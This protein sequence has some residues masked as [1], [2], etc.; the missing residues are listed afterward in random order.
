M[1]CQ[2]PLQGESIHI[3]TPVSEGDIHKQNNQADKKKFH[4]QAKIPK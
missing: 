1:Y 3:G 4:T 2:K